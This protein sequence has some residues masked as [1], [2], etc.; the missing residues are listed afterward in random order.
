[1]ENIREIVSQNIHRLRKQNNLTQLELAKKVNFSDKAVSRWEK[2]EVL[3][4]LETLQKLSEIFDVS[5]SQL[6]ESKSSEETKKTY[7]PNRNE[8]LFQ[9]LLIC[10]IWSI[11]TVLFTYL[12]LIYD[13]YYWQAFVWA[14]PLTLATTFIANFKGSSRELKTTLASFVTWTTIASIYLQFLDQNLWLIFIIGIPIQAAII[15][16]HFIP[17]K[18]KKSK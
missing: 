10:I 18:K 16:S 13:M 8:M 17:A 4:D 12:Q 11:S 1:M 9:G 15:V 2:G 5:L 6:I 14:I 3:P 7:K